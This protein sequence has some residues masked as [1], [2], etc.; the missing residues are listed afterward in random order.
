M[1]CLG[2]LIFFLHSSCI[3]SCVQMRSF[4]KLLAVPQIFGTS[5]HLKW[6]LPVFSVYI[7][8]KTK[9]GKRDSKQ[10]TGSFVRSCLAILLPSSQEVGALLTS[11]QLAHTLHCNRPWIAVVLLST[12][13]GQAFLGQAVFDYQSLQLPF[14]HSTGSIGQVQ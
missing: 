1:L 5:S 14:W 6:L 4:S 7:E 9:A 11:K 8:N 13:L 2:P 10:S 3:H 12:C